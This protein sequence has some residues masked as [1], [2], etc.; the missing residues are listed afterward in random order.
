VSGLRWEEVAMLA[1][2]SV[3]CVQVEALGPIDTVT[4][5]H[6]VYERLPDGR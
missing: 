6:V 2:I 4:S 5:A 1:G 3:E